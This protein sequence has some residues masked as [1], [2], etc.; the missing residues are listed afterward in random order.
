MESLAFSA[1]SPGDGVQGAACCHV[2]AAGYPRSRRYLALA[3]ENC[4]TMGAN[5]LA[6]QRIREFRRLRSAKSCRVAWQLD[7]QGRTMKRIG[8]LLP[9]VVATS[10]AGGAGAESLVFECRA[11]A[12]V[13]A[14]EELRLACSAVE[15]ELRKRFAAGSRGLAVRLDVT[16]LDKHRISGRLSWRTGQ[17]GGRFT[18]GPSISTSISDAGLNARTIA[19]FARDLVQVSHTDF[20]RL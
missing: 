3:G 14:S 20:N 8:K 1:G 2:L 12:G 11:E 16:A 4:C 5:A 18:H 6:T 10:M 9:F 7:L 19:K 17:S 13:V 15:G